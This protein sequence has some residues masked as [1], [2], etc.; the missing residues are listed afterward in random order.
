MLYSIYIFIKDKFFK[1]T[2]I[3]PIKNFH[4]VSHVSLNIGYLQNDELV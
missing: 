1:K 3:E 2:E 4:S